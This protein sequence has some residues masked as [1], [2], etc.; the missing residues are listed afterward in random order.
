MAMQ[1]ANSPARRDFSSISALQGRIF[2]KTGVY[3]SSLKMREAK[4][5]NFSSGGDAA[6]I[7]NQIIILAKLAKLSP[8]SVSMLSNLAP[9]LGK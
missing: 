7:E 5:Y 3:I 6:K 8:L 2:A 4:T 9:V 1:I